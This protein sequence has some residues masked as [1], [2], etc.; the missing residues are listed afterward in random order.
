MV[1]S[2]TNSGAFCKDFGSVVLSE[3]TDSI[4]V[5]YSLILPD[6]SSSS[7]SENYSP[8]ENGIVRIKDLGELAFTFFDP[9]PMVLSGPQ[10]IDYT[11]LINASVYDSLGT[12]LGQ[13][14]Q[15]FFYANCRTNL[16]SP[17]SFLGFLS[18]HHRRSISADQA[19]FIGFIQ[20]GQQLGVG[21]SYRKDKAQQWSEFLMDTDDNGKIFYQNL[22]VITVAQ[23]LQSKMGPIISADDIF[24]YIVYLKANG[25][26]QDAMQ[27]DVDRTPYP[28]ATHMVYYNGF[29]IPDSLRFTGKDHRTSEIDAAYVNVQHNFLKINTKYHIY[30]DVNTGFINGA[31][32]DCFEDLVNCDAPVYLYNN[33]TLGDRITITEVNFDDSTPRTEPINAR[34]KYRLSSEYQHA[35]DRDMTVDY[36]IFDHTFGEEFE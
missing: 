32:R 1:V 3:L 2:G 11:L 21:V 5:V 28:Y 36:R 15:K 26:V 23:L 18:R 13:F 14:S 16:R 19:H 22:D 35:I 7:F 8:N 34:I 12:F 27:V 33:W 17:H 24:Y 10:T 30:H 25:E 9:L 4:S 20:N 31:M 6:G 29:G